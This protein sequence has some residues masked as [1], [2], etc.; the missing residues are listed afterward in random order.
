MLETP[1]D[2]M[3]KTTADKTPKTPKEQP[4]IEKGRNFVVFHK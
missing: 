2:K 3:P 4:N 1:K